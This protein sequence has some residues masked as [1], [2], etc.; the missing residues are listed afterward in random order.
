[1]AASLPLSPDSACS[2]RNIPLGYHDKSASDVETRRAGSL[3][4]KDAT[5]LARTTPKNTLMSIRDSVRVRGF[6]TV[7]SSK[8]YF[9]TRS[10]T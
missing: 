10:L 4:Q 5:H 2:V 6:H 8:I 3:A 1:M 7:T 9:W